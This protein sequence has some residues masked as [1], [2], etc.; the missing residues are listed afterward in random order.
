[1]EQGQSKR[2]TGKWCGKEQVE[3][4]EKIRGK[5]KRFGVDRRGKLRQGVLES[6]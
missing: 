1:M 2:G 6:V 5:W 4:Y 3:G